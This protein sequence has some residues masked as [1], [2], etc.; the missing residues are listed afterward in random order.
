MFAFTNSVNVTPVGEDKAAAPTTVSHVI[1]QQI[2][3]HL[4]SLRAEKRLQGPYAQNIKDLKTAISLEP[5]D[6]NAYYLLAKIYLAT[7]Q[8]DLADA[9]AAEACDIEPKNASYQVCRAKTRELLGE[10]D[11]AVLGV[12]AILDRADLTQ[13][14][15]AEALHQMAHL[16]SFGDKE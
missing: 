4:F 2:D 8:A 12:R 13:I 16:A 10:Y 14:D 15:R 1:I 5:E 11:D 3:S 9:A 6:A 7:G